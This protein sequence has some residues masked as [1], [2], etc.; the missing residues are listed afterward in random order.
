MTDR[1]NHGRGRGVRAIYHLTDEISYVPL[2]AALQFSQC[3]CASTEHTSGVCGRCWGRPITTCLDMMDYTC[4]CSWGTW[5]SICPYG[6]EVYD[7]FSF[8][9]V[10]RFWVFQ[11]FLHLIETVGRPT[12]RCQNEKPAA[13]ST[14]SKLK[15]STVNT[16]FIYL[17]IYSFIYLFI[18]D[19]LVSKSQLYS[20]WFFGIYL[21]FI[22]RI[23]SSKSFLSDI[24]FPSSCD[25]NRILF[26]CYI[27][28][29]YVINMSWVVLLYMFYFTYHIFLYSVTVPC[30]L[31]I[32][33]SFYLRTM[34]GEKRKMAMDTFQLAQ[35]WEKNWNKNK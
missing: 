2:F 1:R 3:V 8:F 30:F 34:I 5:Q 7:L 29:C 26:F 22:W 13:S 31:F 15:H 32:L 24:V 10:S 4:S 11:I 17:F 20:S 12:G 28:T 6:R 33:L 35:M 9:T 25:F 23:K 14:F 27:I 21:N 16:N 19:H 18:R